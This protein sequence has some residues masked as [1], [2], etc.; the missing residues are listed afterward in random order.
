MVKTVLFSPGSVRSPYTNTGF[1][2]KMNVFQVSP[3]LVLYL[4]ETNKRS[5]E[6]VVLEGRPQFLYTSLVAIT[7]GL[8]KGD[9]TTG[10]FMVVPEKQE[11]VRDRQTYH[12]KS[13]QTLECHSLLGSPSNLPH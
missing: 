4:P 5:L 11:S 9:L 3:S 12:L 13:M 8:G 6:V 1:S 10:K 2:E 7:S